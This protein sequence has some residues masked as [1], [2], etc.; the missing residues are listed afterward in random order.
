MT[1]ITPRLQ[2]FGIP[3][4]FRIVFSAPPEKITEACERIGEFF[5]SH[6]V[7]AE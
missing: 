2:I 7:V 5:R 1:V 3:G 4:Y 6:R